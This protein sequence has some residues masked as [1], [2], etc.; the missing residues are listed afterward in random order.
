MPSPEQQKKSPFLFLAS[1]PPRMRR[2]QF[3]GIKEPQRRL[4]LALLT[5]AVCLPQRSCLT[6]RLVQQAWYG[7]DAVLPGVSRP[8]ISPSGSATVFKPFAKAWSPVQP[9]DYPQY[10]LLTTVTCTPTLLPYTHDASFGQGVFKFILPFLLP[11][12]SDRIVFIYFAIFNSTPPF[13][14]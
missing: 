14:I 6:G 12:L 2:F 7:E 5:L 9:T 10:Q 4:Q 3:V 11:F 8:G 13:G 1:P